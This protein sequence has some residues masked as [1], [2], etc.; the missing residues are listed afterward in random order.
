MAARSDESFVSYFLG[1][2]LLTLLVA[3]VIRSIG[4]RYGPKGRS[5]L[6]PWVLV[7]ATGLALLIVV[8][9]ALRDASRPPSCDTPTR[10]ADQLLGELPPGLSTQPAA[11]EL[12]DQLTESLR[13]VDLKRVTAIAITRGESPQAALV[14]VEA[15]ERIRRRDIVGGVEQASGSSGTD[16]PLGETKGRM[17]VTANGGA[18]VVGVAGPCAAAIVY[19]ATAPVAQRVAETLRVPAT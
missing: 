3:V 12:I 7:M 11:P 14:S 4:V 13:E 18:T 9:G 15:D 2:L 1:A 10:S 8:G 17:I 5:L 6:S 16:V 19:G